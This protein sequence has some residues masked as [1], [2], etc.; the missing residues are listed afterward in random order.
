M[1]SSKLSSVIFSTPFT[2][3]VDD[4]PSI[5]S[6]WTL[7]FSAFTDKSPVVH[8]EVDGEEEYAYFGNPY[9]NVSIY[10]LENEPNQIKLYGVVTDQMS[11]ISYIHSNSQLNLW[12]SATK[13]GYI[14]LYTSPRCKL[15]RSIKV[16]TQNCEYIFLISS[17]LPSIIAIVSDNGASR[18]LLYSINGKF[19]QSQEEEDIISCPIIYRELNTCEYLVY[20]SNGKINMRTIPSLGIIKVIDNYPNIYALFF[21]EDKKLYIFDKTGNEINILRAF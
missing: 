8:I 3:N 12:A 17:P 2:D 6:H 21:G 10:K 13:D 1:L 9:G 14:N 11:Y 18:I 20:I 19:L 4:V 16:D 7:E 5:N 15:V